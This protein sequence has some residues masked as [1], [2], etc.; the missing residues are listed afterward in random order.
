MSKP[1]LLGA[2]TGYLI[3]CVA[4]HPR[5]SQLWEAT[6]RGEYRL[7]IP[8]LVISEY[9]AYGIKRGV[10]KEAEEFVDELRLLPNV[11]IVP[12]SLEIA[13]L[14]ARYRLG[15]GI[16]TVD[17]IILTTFLEAGCN[18]ILTTDSDLE[19]AQK[20]GLIEVELLTYEE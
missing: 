13:A 14:S 7:V 12:V 18:L 9:L 4:G 11:E 5:A 19:E 10:L 3:Q 20:Q 16:P 8:V 15:L 17:S 6:K 1:R 2:D